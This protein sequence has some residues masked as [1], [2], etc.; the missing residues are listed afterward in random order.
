MDVIETTSPGTLFDFEAL[1]TAPLQRDPFDFVMVPAFVRPDALAIANA[2]FPQMSGPGNHDVA[3]LTLGRGFQDLVECIQSAAMR[4][5]VEEKFGVDIHD[6]RLNISV[7]GYC[8]QSDGNIHTDHWTK[9]LAGLI[10]FN[11]EWPHEGGRLRML[12]SATDIED[13]AAEVVPEKGTLLL[14]RRTDDS[15]HGHKRFVG[16]RRILQMSWHIPTMLARCSR[17]LGRVGTHLVKFVDRR[18]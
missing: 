13:Y 1:R 16:E 5:A 4:E 6:A 18:M 8:E 12:R 14:F 2:D 15:Y 10:Y 17:S 9:I 11:E 7:R 3:K